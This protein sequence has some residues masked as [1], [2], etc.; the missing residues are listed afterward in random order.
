MFNAHVIEFRAK[1]MNAA[2]S[3]AWSGPPENEKAAIAAAEKAAGYKH[4]WFFD[5][6]VG[7]AFQNDGGRGIVWVDQPVMD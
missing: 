7:A 1:V 2:I 5:E 3:A 6:L 4:G